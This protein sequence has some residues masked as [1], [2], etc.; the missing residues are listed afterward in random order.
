MNAAGEITGYKTRGADT[1]HPFSAKRDIVLGMSQGTLQS[2]SKLQ[3]YSDKAPC[4]GT[5]TYTLHQSSIQAYA[6][7]NGVAF[8][9][10]TTY[11]TNVGYSIKG[12]LSVKRGDVI[13]IST[14]ERLGHSNSVLFVGRYQ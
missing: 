1:V 10:L 6:W 11:S 14:G 8:A 12:T 9:S 4:D 5:I 7:K 13:S 2:D 3:Y